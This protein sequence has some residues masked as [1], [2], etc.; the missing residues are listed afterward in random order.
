MDIAIQ[1][2]NGNI[3]VETDGDKYHATPKKSVGDNLRNNALTE[4]GWQVLRFSTVQVREKMESYCIPK[5]AGTIDNLGG[6][7]QGDKLSRKINLPPADKPYQ[8]SL[9]D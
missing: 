3:N 4:Y 2:T 7:N 5:I 9:F 6:L 1:C 8:P